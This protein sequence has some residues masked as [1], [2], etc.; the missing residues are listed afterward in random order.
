MDEFIVREV[1]QGCLVSHAAFL[2]NL[3]KDQNLDH[4]FD[5]KTP[6]LMDEQAKA[7]ANNLGNA[8]KRKRK[9]KLY[10]DPINEKCKKILEEMHA[11]R[12]F[13][14]QPATDDWIEN[15]KAA[16]EKAKVLMSQAT[17]NYPTIDLIGMNDSDEITISKNRYTLPPHCQYFSC[18]IK[19]IKS[20]LEQRKFKVII[21]DPPWENKHV[22]RRKN[23]I[24]GYQML[25]NED[26]ALQLPIPDLLEKEGIIAIWC[27]N[28][29][30]HLD[31]IDSWLENWNLVQKA[32]WYWL[33]ITKFGEPITDWTHP[34]KKPYEQIIIATAQKDLQI[35][36]DYV[37]ASV[38]SIIHSH[39]PPIFPLL[40]KRGI[41]Q[42]QEKLLEIFGRYLLPNCTTYGNQC[43]LLQDTIFN[44]K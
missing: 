11:L 30:R 1:D 15:N 21:M 37:F 18:D 39:K 22:K 27:T 35:E 43:L 6:F 14:G 25:S 34:H 12:L 26:L 24:D 17:S 29:Q 28:S 33:K 8:D 2:R 38:P 16:R 31:A 10:S 20:K 23:K 40:Q 7:R 42:G 41:F 32:K 4:L 19:N 13:S 9:R 36:N 44:C 3:Y 5:V